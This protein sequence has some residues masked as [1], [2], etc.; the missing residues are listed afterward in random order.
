[1]EGDLVRCGA[2]GRGS[3][4]IK[5]YAVAFLDTKH[6]SIHMLLEYVLI[7]KA[8]ICLSEFNF[9]FSGLGKVR[10]CVKLFRYSE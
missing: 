1:M 5:S 4:F 3:V 8:V 2:A 9:K 7:L 6:T 10:L